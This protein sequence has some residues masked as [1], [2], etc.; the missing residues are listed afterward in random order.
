ME[1]DPTGKLHF[2]SIE[3]Q[4]KVVR[5]GPHAHKSFA[6]RYALRCLWSEIITR[7][8]LVDLSISHI[9]VLR[10]SEESLTLV[11]P[12]IESEQQLELPQDQLLKEV[13]HL[14]QVMWVNKEDPYSSYRLDHQS[15]IKP[16]KTFAKFVYSE[17]ERHIQAHRSEFLVG[18]HT[19]VL[20]LLAACPEVKSNFLCLL[21]V[22]PKNVFLENGQLYHFDFEGTIVGPRDYFLC[23]TA[24]NFVRDSNKS[25]DQAARSA[26]KLIE[27]CENDQLVRS[28]LAYSL[29]RMMLFN[30]IVNSKSF[31]PSLA[32]QALC[33]GADFHTV[34][35]LVRELHQSGEISEQ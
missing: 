6:S 15:R 5:V 13:I 34:L 31:K 29:T 2:S 10:Y 14:S 7:E 20:T 4:N 1:P 3:S 16:Q 21:D 33:Q 32:L 19:Q 28:S 8:L 17:V 12:W 26:M 18:L 9:P 35:S 23:R 25:T 11:M 22:S 30:S 27:Q 24:L